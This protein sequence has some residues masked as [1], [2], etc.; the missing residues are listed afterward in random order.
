MECKGR[1]EKKGKSYTRWECR[2]P[3][4]KKKEVDCELGKGIQNAYVHLL[5]GTCYGKSGVE[6]QVSGMVVISI[7]TKKSH[8]YTYIPLIG[9]CP[10][11]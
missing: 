2:N 5:T 11:Y 8:A 4:C 3:K 6:I 1:V 9:P 7:E 10:L